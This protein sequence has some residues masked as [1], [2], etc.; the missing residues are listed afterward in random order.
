ML[1][2]LYCTVQCSVVQYVVVPRTTGTGIALAFAQ[3]NARGDTLCAHLLSASTSPQCPFINYVLRA[4]D[5]TE[6]WEAAQTTTC[7]AVTPCSLALLYCTVSCSTMT[8]RISTEQDRRV[9]IIC[10]TAFSE[11]PVQYTYKLS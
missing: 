9:I 1:C 6:Q 10:I 7:A 2:A 11:Y 3:V 8:E 4:Q 5:R